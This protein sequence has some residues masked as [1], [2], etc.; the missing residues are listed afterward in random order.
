MN[1]KL[2]DRQNSV[3]ETIR[4]HLNENHLSIWYDHMA[5]PS[6][7]VVENYYSLMESKPICQRHTL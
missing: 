3:I 1:G 4:R 5:K 2:I 6:R 7:G